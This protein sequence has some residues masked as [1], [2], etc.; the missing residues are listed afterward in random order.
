MPNAD[1][2]GY[3]RWSL[4]P[5]DLGKLRKNGYAKLSVRER[6]SF[7][8]SVRAA[9]WRGAIAEKDGL[10]ALENFA[11]DSD[12]A[13]AAEP[14]STLRF[15]RD[16]LVPES[17]R[18]RVEAYAR[19]L[20][21]P[22]YDRHG[23]T[24]PAEESRLARTFRTSVLEFLIETGNDPE[25]RREAARRGRAFAGLAD[26]KFHPEAV[27]PDLAEIALAAA[28]AEDGKPMFDALEERLG[29]EEDTNVRELTLTA[30][31]YSKEPAL[32][33]RA[34]ALSLDPRLKQNERLH[35]LFVA[36]YRA[37]SRERAWTFLQA[38]IDPLS[39][40][41]SESLLA[42]LASAGSS[43]CDAKHLGEVEALLG[44]RVEK[45]M[46]A[47]KVLRESQERVRGCI[48]QVDAQ[49]ASTA[50]FFAGPGR[51]GEVTQTVR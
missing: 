7:A 21:R 28:T 2:D 18:P 32:L 35:P 51:A 48:A 42:N 43:F 22:S 6:V 24:G 19:K 30:L 44:P 23:W 8:S 25:V 38:N 5:D 34:L 36:L 45:L 40:L 1:A 11:A 10:A 4:A 39:K 31:A 47:L 29:A 9:M 20:Y 26:K 17:L 3:Y 16:H 14:I 37:E 46:G 41:L 15:V 49:R 13:V 27:D 33:D 50:E 12:G